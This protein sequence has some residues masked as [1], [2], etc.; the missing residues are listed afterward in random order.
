MTEAALR[1]YLLGKLSESEVD[2]VENRLVEDPNYFSELEVAEDDLFDAYARGQLDSDDRQRFLARFGKDESRRQFAEALAART[3]PAKVVPMRRGYWMPLAAA[4]T[5]LIGVYLVPW[6]GAQPADTPSTTAPRAIAPAA[7]TEV[8][9][10]VPL[11]LGLSRATGGST[12]VSIDSKVTAADFAIRINAGDRFP[13]YVAELRSSDGHLAWSSST[14]TAAAEDGEI[15]VHAKIPADRLAAGSYELRLRG[16]ATTSSVDD[17]G[18]LMI[19][20][21]RIP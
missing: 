10:R 5:L 6:R 19:A 15:V 20:V 16:G 7:P 9:M 18:F 17:L 1:A 14:L 4:A 13:A 3:S 21:T 11:A 8:L 2:L 12:P